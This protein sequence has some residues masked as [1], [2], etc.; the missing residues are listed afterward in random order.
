MEP[1]LKYLALVGHSDSSKTNEEINYCFSSVNHYK[2]SV[3]FV[4]K[5]VRSEQLQLCSRFNCTNLPVKLLSELI[6]V[7]ESLN[8]LKST[9]IVILLYNVHQLS[10]IKTVLET[11]QGKYNLCIDEVE[12]SIKT[13]TLVTPTDTLMDYLKN[14]AIHILSAT[15]TPCMIFSNESNSKPKLHVNSRLHVKYITDRKSIYDSILQKD[16]AI[17][18]HT[19][20]KVKKGH[21]SLFEE[22][23]NEYPGLTLVVYNGD[24]ITVRCNQRNSLFKNHSISEV[25]NLL[26]NETHISII[27]GNK[28]SGSITDQYLQRSQNNVVFNL[29]SDLTLWCSRSTWKSVIE[30]NKLIQSSIESKEWMVK[31]K[32]VILLKN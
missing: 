9:G 4:V 30:Q 28:V 23:S 27:S 22:L 29:E 14:S 16:R 11:Y 3:L 20:T 31:I 10:K 8:F 6:T 25:L 13:K 18:L 5:N 26:K 15:S 21:Y 1:A 2:T 24:G 17:L 12:F 32:E 7:E 19:V